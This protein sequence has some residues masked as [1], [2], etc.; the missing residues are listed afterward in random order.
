M[1]RIPGAK[2]TMNLVACGKVIN[3]MRSF[4]LNAEPCRGFRRW[5]VGVYGEIGRRSDAWDHEYIQ[6]DYRG[7][8]KS[9]E[10]HKG[11]IF[12]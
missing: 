8:V 11:C 10:P 12:L 5:A 6:R 3:P 2:A 4:G 1:G 9:T 7:N